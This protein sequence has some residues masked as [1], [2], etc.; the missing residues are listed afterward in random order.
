[1]EKY[2]LNNNLPYPYRRLI[3]RILDIGVI[4]IVYIIFGILITKIV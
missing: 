4:G 2:S 3:I 1:M